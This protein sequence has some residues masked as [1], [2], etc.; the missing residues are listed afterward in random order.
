MEDFAYIL[1]ENDG[2]SK[3][4]PDGVV[5]IM[6]LECLSKNG[7]IKINFEKNQFEFP[8]L[9][10]SLAVPYKYDDI[11]SQSVKFPII[12]FNESNRSNYLLSAIFDLGYNGSVLI[13]KNK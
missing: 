4:V 2:T 6:P 3:W 12:L 9:V 1:E 10:D 7:I 11:R 13:L 8:E 5:G